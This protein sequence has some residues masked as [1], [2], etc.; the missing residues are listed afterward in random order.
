VVLGMADA[1]EMSELATLTHP[2]PFGPE[3]YRLGLFVGLREQGRLVAMAGQRLRIPGYVEISGVCTHP[4]WQGRGLARGLMNHLAR[5]IQRQ[6]DTPFLHVLEEN[7]RAV[8]LYTRMGFTLRKRLWVR[9]LRR[10]G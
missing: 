4:G 5:E 10:V 7:T 1:A 6:G 3:L 8:T 2:G 9:I